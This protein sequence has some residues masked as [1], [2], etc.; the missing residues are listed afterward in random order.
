M[1]F[2]PVI[3]FAVVCVAPIAPAYA[4]TDLSAVA[5]EAGVTPAAPVR[6][7]RTLK[8]GTEAPSFETS[9]KRAAKGFLYCLAGILALT[10]IAKKFYPRLS[11]T[12]RAR[13]GAAISISAR[14][15]L[16]SKSELVLVTVNGEELLLSSTESGAT[17]LKAFSPAAAQIS[18]T[19]SEHDRTETMKPESL[20]VV[21]G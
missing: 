14:Q 1:Q 20:K 18:L 13:P 4:Q 21:R 3:L 2:G 17:L 16:T 6:K 15:A 9:S 8:I 10:S 5:Q 12:R 11:L 19:G 7:A